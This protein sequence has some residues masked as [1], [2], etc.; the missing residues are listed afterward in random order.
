MKSI[1]KAVALALGIA[2]VNAVSAMS[3]AP[4]VS[5]LTRGVGTAEQG[6]V[7]GDGRYAANGRAIALYHPTY[8]ARI[9]AP[10]AMAREYLAQRGSQLGLLATD[11]ASLVRTHLR[12]GRHFSVVRFAQYADGLPIY[13]SDVAVSVQPNGKVIYV[14]NA[15]VDADGPV[16]NSV[17]RSSADAV[18][19]ARAHL[20][21]GELRHQASQKML[22]ATTDGLRI[23]WRVEAIAKAG[24]RGDWELLV[25]AQSGEVLR[26]EDRAAYADGQATVFGPDPLSSAR[27]AYGTAGYVD[28]NNADTPQ[29]T[30][31]LQAVT[32]EDIT[33][34]GGMHSLSGPYAVC[35]D[36]DTPHDAGCPVQASADL[37]MTRSALGFDGVMG[38]YHISTLMKYINETLGI[39]VM[40]INHPGGVHYDPHGFDGDDNSFFS[41]STEALSFGGGGVD[42]AQDAD[43]LA[44]ELGHGIHHFVTGGHLSQVQGLSEGVGDYFAASWSRHYP[45]QW[46]PA[47]TAYFWTYNWDGHNPFWAGRLLNW[48][49]SHTY[50]SN[51]GSGSY[52]QSQYWS[53]CNAHA[54]DVLGRE[55][56]DTIFLEGLS[57]TG[58]STNQGDA[59]QA[60]MNAAV[61]LGYTNAQIQDLATVYN[62]GTGSDLN[63]TY[64][65]TVPAG[66]PVVSIDPTSLAG[67]AEAGASTTLALSIGNTG[68]ADLDWNLDAGDDCA[69]PATPAWISFAP[70]SGTIAS[71]AGDT[72][73]D[74]V[75]DAATLA[76]GD[77]STNVCVHSNDADTPVVAVPV[78]FTV[79]VADDVIFADGF[80]GAV[81]EC[82]PLQ[83]LADP[84]FES[85]PGS[86]GE[87]P[88]WPSETTQGDSVFWG[89]DGGAEQIHTGTFVAW[90]GGY[91]SATPET[92][93]A[94][95]AVVI[96]SGS[97][98]Y[99]NYWRFISATGGGS[100]VVTFSIDGEAVATE[101]LVGLGEDSA[102]TSHSV[103]VSEW[104]DGATHTVEFEYVF[105]G[106]ATDA[107]Y[108]LD[109]VTLDC[110]AAPAASP[111]RTTVETQAMRVYKRH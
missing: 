47:D 43:V 52:A 26:A 75:L 8:T 14:A 59:A 21:A 69:T 107:N 3:A 110:T 106:G 99:L 33:L 61:A 85:T 70:A 111:A 97:A 73:V 12:N 22:Y 108:Y 2:T 95:Q 48:Q 25:D 66:G 94:S 62:D 15:A 105:G 6:T 31:E 71:G 58:G 45:G 76:A 72:A 49:T 16:V 34:S 83:L 40:P 80:D 55:A 96:P 109:D 51:L 29:L 7:R 36:F 17:S 92:H 23:V 37:S 91:G 41:P 4:P 74:V 79:T 19:I 67:S 89:A 90:L 84:S 18:G 78:E 82:E 86:G 68:S 30:A 11:P 10:E 93:A 65:V 104:A 9:G 53:S 54:Y 39:E 57:M 60:V 20:G 50:P 13:G 32:L 102:W 98:R 103:D 42:D 87:N 63:C 81:A 88:S 1:S 101:D 35:D 24:P 77:Y 38:Y 27:V 46:T 44:H 56:M 64:G 5:N 28:G 100:N